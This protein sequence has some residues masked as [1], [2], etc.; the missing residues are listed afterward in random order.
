MD[1]LVYL[2]EDG[3]VVPAERLIGEIWRGRVVEESAVH[4]CVS[5]IRR[6][7]GDD[8]QNPRYLESIPR[9]GYRI[10]APT[11]RV[12]MAEV[13]NGIERPEGEGSLLRRVSVGLLLAVSLLALI[14]WSL[15]ERSRD[16]GPAL[17]SVAVLPLENLSGDPSQNYFADGMTEMIITELGKVPSLRVISRLSV[18]DY[19][20]SKLS[21]R[22][23]ARQL[24]VDMIVSGAVTHFGDRMQ[25][26]VNLADGSSGH[27]TWSD[28]FEGDLA[29][30]LG[31]QS[32]IGRELASRIVPEGSAGLPEADAVPQRIDPAVYEDYL[33]AVQISSA[34][35]ADTV[36]G[37]GPRVIPILERVIDADPGFASAWALLA[38]T[39]VQL[40]AAEGVSSTRARRAAERALALQPEG[41][42]AHVA[43]GLVELNDWAF[44][45]AGEALRK[46]VRLGPNNPRALIAYAKYLL[47]V[48][49]RVD[50]AL[51]LSARVPLLD[52]FHPYLLRE[53]AELLWAS[54]RFEQAL[55][56]SRAIRTR[57]PEVFTDVEWIVYLAVG[58]YR[59]GA[60]V[61][62]RLLQHVCPEGC[63]WAEAATDKGRQGGD[64]AAGWRA[65]REGAIARPEGKGRL[66]AIV[67]T[68]LGDYEDALAWLERAYRDREPLLYT[69][70]SRHLFD[71]LREDPRFQAL[72]ERIGFPEVDPDPGTMAGMGKVLAYQ[73]RSDEAI[74]ALDRAIALSPGDDR[75]PTWLYMRA[76]AQFGAANYEESVRVAGEALDLSPGRYTRENA[77]LLRATS[78]AL[79]GRLEPARA[80]LEQVRADWPSLAL[81]LV[82][83]PPLTDPELRGRYE[84]GLKALGLDAEPG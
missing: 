15:P 22:E 61:V 41:S 82:P 80:A 57:F 74:A 31:T 44:E 27:V 2:M 77:L 43:M 81:A 54:R 12:E 1:V 51:E 16:S 7:L 75:L 14:V 66:I 67:S 68:W 64:F 3:G 63:E 42:D 73:G 37:W 9:R 6:A 18:R 19:R 84:Q 29:D 53:R 47:D 83:L 30:A 25:I 35:S 17:P 36:E 34:S 59:Q 39:L 28:A 58:R 78:L 69:L 13:A 26:A 48:E 72:V 20:D 79:L 32:R 49:S 76:L 23:I 52:P 70:R 45:Q 62:A 11:E 55:D 50:E 5:K 8:R 38:G 33:R 21:P 56:E 10:V 46:A 71:P 24:K 60:D 65:W 4:Q 40:D